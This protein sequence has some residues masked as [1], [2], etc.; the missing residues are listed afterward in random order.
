MTREVESTRLLL[1]F[2]ASRL[3]AAVS[4]IAAGIAERGDD[5]AL[6][7]LARRVFAEPSSLVTVHGGGRFGCEH[8]VLAPGDGLLSLM[9]A[10]GLKAV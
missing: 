5:P 6:A 9:R 2:D 4:R 7:E 1:N 8:V 10:L 3:T